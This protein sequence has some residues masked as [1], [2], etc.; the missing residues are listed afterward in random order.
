MQLERDKSGRVRVWDVALGKWVWTQPVDARQGIEG[1]AFAAVG[2]DDKPPPSK[3]VPDP[4]QGRGP[5]P[6]KPDAKK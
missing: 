6:L 5:A 2:P 4:M 1:G 3:P